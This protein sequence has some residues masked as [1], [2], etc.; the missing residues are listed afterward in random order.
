M[1]DKHGGLLQQTRQRLGVRI[2]GD[3]YKYENG[4]KLFVLGLSWLVVALGFVCSI[5]IICLLFIQ[6]LV[7]LFKSMG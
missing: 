2:L 3:A 1:T 5:L 6:S 4:T 7:N